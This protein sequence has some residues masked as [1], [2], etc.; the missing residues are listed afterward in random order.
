MCSAETTANILVSITQVGRDENGAVVSNS[1]QIQV[2]QLGDWDFHHRHPEQLE[3]ARHRPGHTGLYLQAGLR[4][5]EPP[6]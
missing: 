6:G 3:G 5:S 1:A 2:D 4:G